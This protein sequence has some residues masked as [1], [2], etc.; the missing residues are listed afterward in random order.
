MLSALPNR[1]K[2]F[3]FDFRC[4]SCTRASLGSKRLIR[5]QYGN[6]GLLAGTRISVVAYLRRMN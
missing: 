3:H 2:L 5:K 1:I 6:I 4:S